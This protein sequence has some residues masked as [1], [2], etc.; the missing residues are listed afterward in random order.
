VD[1]GGHAKLADFGLSV[2]IIE[3]K[4]TATTSSGTYRWSAPE[5]FV[6][7]DVHRKPPSDIYSFGCTCLE[8]VTYR[9]TDKINPADMEKIEAHTRKPPFSTIPSD[10]VVVGRIMN[11]E[12]PRWP[13]AP[14]RGHDV[15]AGVKELFESCCNSDPTQRPTAQTI[16][17]ALAL[18]IG[19]DVI[20]NS[21]LSIS[22]L[23]K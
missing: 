12:R 17:K 11:G 9:C 5:L 22:K 16:V 7:G 1:E 21:R 3:G 23:F 15:S 18:E 10:H 6:D 14:A 2:L 4:I 8:V 13:I 19:Q 20:V